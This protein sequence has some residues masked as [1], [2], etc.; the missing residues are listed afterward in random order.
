MFKNIS[1]LGAVLNANEQKEI[2]GGTR[3]PLCN[4]GTCYPVNSTKVLVGSTSNGSPCG[5]IFGSNV[6]RGTVNFGSC[7]VS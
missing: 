6:C 7:C 2:N 4:S 3:V 5:V 1:K